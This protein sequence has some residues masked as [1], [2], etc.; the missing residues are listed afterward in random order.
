[1]T[2]T[3]IHRLID[4]VRQNEAKLRRFQQMELRLM[5]AESLP[6]LCTALVSEYPR[7]FQLDGVALH[8]FDPE[9]ELMRLEY[10]R[11]LAALR[12]VYL[13]HAADIPLD[14]LCGT[15]P[16][17]GA[18]D[19]QLHHDVF[20][21]LRR[22]IASVAI[23]PLRRG[24]RRVGL[25]ALGSRSP[26][27]FTSS[28]GT[29]FLQRLAAVAGICVENAMNLERLRQTGL[30]DA[31]TQLYNRRHF[32]DSLRREIRV[33]QRLGRPLGCL[34]MDIDHFKKIN[35]RHGH[36]VG[37]LVL[38]AVADTLRRQQR[39]SEIL[40]R[41]GGE[42]FALLMPATDLDAALKAAER[43]REH[44]AA[45]RHEYAPRAWIEAS[46]SC[47]VASLCPVESEDPDKAAERLLLS[48]D[49]AL[50]HAKQNGRNCVVGAETD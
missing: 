36:P 9:R 5:A 40:A 29:E 45:G 49:N 41:L 6:D 19:A 4:E 12:D 13:H 46:I 42:E 22:A 35:D 23:L 30:R 20:P 43:I 38:R 26:R 2:A 24:S 25:F 16:R 21:D 27:R 3:D 15:R 18:Y 1:M 33:A 34:Y 11:E 32:D 28:D 48:A 8:L 50:L 39:R 7:D 37:D 17:L 14:R 31:L 44:V 47:G 10:N